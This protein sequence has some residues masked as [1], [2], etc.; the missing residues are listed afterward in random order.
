MVGAGIAAGPN[1]C[2]CVS[3]S[4]GAAKKFITLVTRSAF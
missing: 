4:Y 1:A 2:M 3:S